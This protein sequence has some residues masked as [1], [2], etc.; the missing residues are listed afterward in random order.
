MQTGRDSFAQRQDA[1]RRRIAMMP[2]VKRL[3]GGL[4]NKVGGTEI[5]LTDAEIDDIAA[6]RRQRRGAGEDRERVLLADAIE[7]RNGS[8]HGRHLIAIV[9]EKQTFAE[10]LRCKM[11]G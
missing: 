9:P 3:H 8:Q 4:D 7:C 6:L 1:D 5:R 11:P 2:I 10:M